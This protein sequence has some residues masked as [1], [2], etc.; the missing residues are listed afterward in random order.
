MITTGWT[1][2][3]PDTGRGERNLQ[4]VQGGARS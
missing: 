4:V 1:R 2:Y 3:T